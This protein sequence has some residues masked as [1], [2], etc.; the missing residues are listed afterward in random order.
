[1]K[2]HSFFISFLFII[3]IIYYFLSYREGFQ[4]MENKK[5]VLIG[6][7]ILEN[8]NYSHPSVSEILEET[9][10]VLCLAQDNSTIE[11]TYNQILNIPSHL[12]N[13]SSFVFVSVG[14][15]DILQKYVYG[16][17]EITEFSDINP[18]FQKYENLLLSLQKKMN[19]ATIVLVNIYFPPF[20]YYKKFYSIIES[21]NEKLKFFSEK[22]H[23]Q[24]MNIAEIMKEPEDF[25]FDI[26]PSPIGSK[27]IANKILSYL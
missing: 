3:F 25:S 27:K 14:G 1:M 13:R 26:E 19:L 8:S 4:L 6:D 23:F 20:P 16:N 2:K 5:I 21:W 17:M 11:S 22:N 9:S 12:N 10:S 7:S 24:L 15:N 18:L